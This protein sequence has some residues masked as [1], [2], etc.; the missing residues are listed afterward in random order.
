MV[1]CLGALY[2]TVNIFTVLSILQFTL[3]CHN[4]IGTCT[5]LHKLKFPSHN[6]FI[7]LTHS[8]DFCAELVAKIHYWQ[9]IQ[10]HMNNFQRSTGIHIMLLSDSFNKSHRFVLFDFKIKLG[11]ALFLQQLGAK[12][13]FLVLRQNK[14][15]C[16]AWIL[17]TSCTVLNLMYCVCCH[18][19]I[20]NYHTKCIRRSTFD[21]WTGVL[22]MIAGKWGRF[23]QILQCAI[24]MRR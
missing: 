18:Y 10:E 23:C 21:V 2:I 8:V 12:F 20:C 11:K 17:L 16:T 4:I 22:V 14:R 7:R 3:C 19:S 24:R 5:V 1:Y 13:P 6:N 9:T 15:A